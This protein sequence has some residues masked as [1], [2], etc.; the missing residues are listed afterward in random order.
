MTF[1]DIGSTAL[2][3]KD[4]AA[5]P[6]GKYLLVVEGV[7]GNNAF[8]PIDRLTMDRLGNVHGYRMVGK[9]KQQ[10]ITFHGT[11]QWCCVDQRYVEAQPVK[12]FMKRSAKTTAEYTKF[13][14][15]LKEEFGLKEETEPTVSPYVIPDRIGYL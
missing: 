10:V 3:M 11:R 15:S 9:T 14:T 1:M 5:L 13:T 6:K 4:F 7:L 12:A 2:T 8:L